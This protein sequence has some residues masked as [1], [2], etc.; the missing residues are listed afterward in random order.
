M[1]ADDEVMRF[2]PTPPHTSIEQTQE[3]LSRRIDLPSDRGEDFVVELNG[4]VLGKVGFQSF[5]EIGYMFARRHW[6]QGFAHEALSAIIPRAFRLHKLEYI[7]A[8]VDPQNAASLRLLARFG[9]DED[10]K[11]TRDIQESGELRDSVHL[12]L[13]R[14]NWE[15]VEDHRYQAFCL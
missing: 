15:T 14:S 10:K 8:I 9:F 12:V 11:A 7:L 4:A 5:P 2:A 3:W 1:H 13:T 6:G